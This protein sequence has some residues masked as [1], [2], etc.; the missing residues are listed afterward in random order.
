MKHSALALCL[1]LGAV[2]PAPSLCM[3]AETQ[4]A[5]PAVLAFPGHGEAVY[6]LVHDKFGE[7]GQLRHSWR[8]DGQHYELRAIS[9]TSGLAALFKSARVVQESR[10]ELGGEGL[11]PLQFRHQKKK[12][13]LEVEFDWA[14]RR[15]ELH[16]ETRPLS[17]GTQDMLSFYY[18]L[19]LRRPPGESFALPV[20]SATKLATYAFRRLGVETVR[21]AGRAVEAEHWRVERGEQTIE[22]WLPRG[23]SEL[24]LPLR[25]RLSEDGD[26]LD[27]ILDRFDFNPHE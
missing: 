19:V 22:L 12:S 2:L 4:A 16:D 23:A 24:P 1:G 7:V 6:R 14:Q 3:A 9:E 20:V 17:P 8:H 25:M 21:A 27:Q 11:R 18:Q 15:I 10:G 5:S 13:T 26:H